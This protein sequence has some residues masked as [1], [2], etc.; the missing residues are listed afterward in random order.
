MKLKEKINKKIDDNEALSLMKSLWQNKRYRSIFW[1]IL[2]FIFFTVIITSMRSNYQNMQ[3]DQPSEPTNVS[4]NVEKSLQSLNDYSYELILNDNESII[5]GE[6]SDNTNKF[7]YNGKNYIIVGENI[8]LEKGSNLIK[9]D[10]TKDKNFIVS[11]NKIMIE[12]FNSYI[13]D[14]EP[15]TDEDTVKYKLNFLDSNNEKINFDATFYGK[16]KIEKLE[17]NFNEYIKEKQLDYEEY[18]LTIKIGDVANDNE[19]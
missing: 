19:I 4:L 3:V 6:V 17:L 12:E 2:Y 7:V 15:I 8:Y 16:E 13:K 9:A 1:L 11:L 10:F 5:V 14:L 18:V